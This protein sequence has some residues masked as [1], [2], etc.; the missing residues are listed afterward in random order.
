MKWKSYQLLT[1]FFNNTLIFLLQ[2]SSRLQHSC[3][4]NLSIHMVISTEARG[5]EQF[6]KAPEIL[7]G[8]LRG[9]EAGGA[10]LSSHDPTPLKGKDVKIGKFL[11]LLQVVPYI[12]M[13]ILKVAKPHR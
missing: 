10:S 9:D 12:Y 6:V 2:Y 1:S 4:A 7:R 3:Q 5:N 8:C 13:K 11:F